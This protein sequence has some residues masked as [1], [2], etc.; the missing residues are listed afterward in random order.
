[1]GEE[2]SFMPTEDDNFL[3]PLAAW[4]DTL[5]AGGVAPPCFLHSRCHGLG[6]WTGGSW[7]ISGGFTQG[8][9]S[10]LLSLDLLLI[11]GGEFPSN[12][13]GGRLV[14]AWDGRSW[15]PLDNG[16]SG[17]LVSLASYH[18]ELIAAGPLGIGSAP[19]YG[20]VM[21]RGDGS[22][23]PVGGHLPYTVRVVSGYAN[24]WIA[25]ADGYYDYYSSRVVNRGI[26]RSTG[27][28]WALMGS[29][30][31]NPVQTL[32]IFHGSLIAGGAFS[33][34]GDIQARGL[35]RW[36]GTDWEPFA[37]GVDGTVYALRPAGDSLWVAGDFRLAGG[38]P[39]F[40]I[41]LLVE[42]APSLA[43]FRREH[44]G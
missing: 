29:A 34:F 33:R 25:T 11:A 21:R 31:N 18:G 42:P 2:W 27:Q 3:V 8:T 12:N 41:A 24:G 30:P 6:K 26:Y 17:T 4:R 9:V 39:S 28:E 38:I 23:Q 13:P 19:S 37:G 40:N 7:E 35:A 44:R 1:M 10:A 14:S 20:Q 43:S 16:L 22:W 32:A 36:N 5:F 15:W